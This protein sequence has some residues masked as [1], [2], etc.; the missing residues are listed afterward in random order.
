[1]P[2]MTKRPMAIPIAVFFSMGKPLVGVG[3]N[4]VD[5]SSS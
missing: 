4:L 1:M 3:V 5:Q 2:P